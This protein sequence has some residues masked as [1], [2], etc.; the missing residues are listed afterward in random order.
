M[1]HYE[2]KNFMKPFNDEIDFTLYIDNDHPVGVCEAKYEIDKNG[3]GHVMLIPAVP[4]YTFAH[5]KFEMSDW[6]CPG[7]LGKCVYNT[8]EDPAMDNCLF[9][10]QPYERK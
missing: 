1:Q 10:H 3:N 8:E 9:C 2:L 4:V 6:D 7:P 5:H